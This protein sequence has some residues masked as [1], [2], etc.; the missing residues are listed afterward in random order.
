MRSFGSSLRRIWNAILRVVLSFLTLVWVIFIICTIL[1]VI[2]FVKTWLP[3]MD[4]PTEVPMYGDHGIG[5][6]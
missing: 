1:I 6:F 2:F 4:G 3:M 5:P